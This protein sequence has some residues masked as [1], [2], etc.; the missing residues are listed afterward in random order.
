MEIPNLYK[1]LLRCVAGIDRAVGS[2]LDYLEENGLSE[3]T[4]VVYLIKDFILVALDGL[5]KD[6]CMKNRLEYVCN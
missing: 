6:G 4:I 2:V 1:R 3:N 5:I